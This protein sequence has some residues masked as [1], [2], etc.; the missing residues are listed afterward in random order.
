M[1]DIRFLLHGGDEY[2]QTQ[3]SMTGQYYGIRAC[4]G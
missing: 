3:V 4:A 1:T 2:A